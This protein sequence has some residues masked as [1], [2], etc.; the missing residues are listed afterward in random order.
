MKQS[1]FINGGRCNAIRNRFLCAKTYPLRE[2]Y[3]P[4]IVYG[5]T[6]LQKE[7]SR[8]LRN[9]SF[10]CKA[11]GRCE[12]E[13]KRWEGGGRRRGSWEGKEKRREDNGS[14]QF[15]LSVLCFS[16]TL[17][18]LFPPKHRVY[19]PATPASVCYLYPASV[20]NLKRNKIVQGRYRV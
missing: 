7:I 4:G 2:V 18:Y 16:A 14:L 5:D 11:N 6:A 19:I 13:E 1:T 3:K 9:E 10:S 20:S 17:R 15:L 12:K 8:N